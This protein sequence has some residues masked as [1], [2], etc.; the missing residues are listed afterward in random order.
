MLQKILKIGVVF[1]LLA[2]ALPALAGNIAY[3]HGRVSD[4]GTILNEGEGTAFDP[5]LLSDSGNKGLSEF[6]RLVESQGHTIS[7]YRDKDT[8]LTTEFIGAFD[9]VIF[10]LHQKIWSAAEKTALDTWLNAGGGM[11]IYSD[12]ASGGK[13]SVVGAQNPV[14]Q[15]VTNNLIAAYGMQV[16]VDQADGT[17][18]QTAV[19][20]AAIPDVSSLVLEGEGVSPVAIAQDNT[21]VDILIPYTRNVNKRQGLTISDPNFASLAMRPVGD[22]HIVVMFDRQPMW[23]NGPG[24][25]I[26]EQDN[27]EI[28]RV[29]MN[30]LAERPP[31]PEPPNPPRPPADSPIVVPAIDLL[32]DDSA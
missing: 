7:A 30:F 26:D 6:K 11:F 1:A 31:V 16:T 3:I 25:D 17:T 10:G 12:S 9:V 32:L 13:F 8:P 19:S 28:L 4:D 18:G 23:N 21:Q 15:N 5:M 29:V 2:C 20:A 22:G 24:S 14:G 27:R